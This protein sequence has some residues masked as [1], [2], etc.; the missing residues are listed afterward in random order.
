MIRIFKLFCIT[1]I[2]ALVISTASFAE[3]MPTF[4]NEEIKSMLLPPPTTG[5]EWVIYR[6]CAF[7]KPQGWNQHT[8]PDVPA[9]KIIGA[10][11]TS[12]ETFSESKQFETGFTAQV[13]A[14]FK[15][16]NGLPPSK[17]AILMLKQITDQRTEKDVLVF[18]TKPAQSGSTSFIMRYRDAPEGKTPLVIHKTLIANDAQDTLHIFTFE[19][20]EKNWDESWK[21]GTPIIAKIAV[22]PF[23]PATEPQ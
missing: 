11:S 16:N 1:I 13:V 19:S 2:S 17:G 12:P 20:P 18:D 22:I 10:I 3:T 6:N 9:Q 14:N 23:L 15:A 7:L 5:Y 4:T 21:I 8:L